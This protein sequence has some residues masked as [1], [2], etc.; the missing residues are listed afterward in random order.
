S[1]YGML[2]GDLSAE[3]PR[4]GVASSLRQGVLPAPPRA[5]VRR[6][7]GEPVVLFFYQHADGE[8]V[9]AVMRVDAEGDRLALVRNY[10]F[11]PDVIAEVCGELGL[12]F[13]VNGYKYW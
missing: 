6:H 10:F 4:G 13:R 9:R 12:R 8:A 7:R 11:T 3:D 2:H 1:F 5:E